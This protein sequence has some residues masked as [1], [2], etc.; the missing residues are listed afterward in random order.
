MRGAV[1]EKKGV[2]AIRDDIPMPQI[3]PYDALVKIVSCGFC[4][5]TDMRII[6]AEMSE[7]QGAQPYPL[8]LGHEAAGIIETLG[9]K[10]RHLA[11]GEKHIR[12]NGDGVSQGGKY[13]SM[14][15]QM[16]EYGVLTD[17]QAM[18]EDGLELPDHPFARLKPSRLPD[19]FDLTDA[20]V[21]LPLCECLSAVRNF[22]IDSNT[23]VLIYGAGP[24]GL[25]LMQYMHIVGAKSVVAIDSVPERLQKAVDIANVDEIHNFIT[26]DI[27]AALDGR[28][29]DRV[30][31]AVGLSSVLL[32]GTKRL[33]PFGMLCSLGVL[34]K[35]DSSIDLSYLKNNTRLQMLNFPYREY[36]V[37][38]ENIRY[39]KEGKISP[40][41]YY[42][43]VLPIE[44]INEAIELVRSKEAIKVI[45]TL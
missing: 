12:I 21:L 22:D 7:I 8:V 34:K 35:G 1:V 19:D 9:E 45:M 13:S 10:V 38:D 40:K 30:I 44:K 4:N 17:W 16:A 28:L 2:V 6:D 27:D 26:E 18:A 36:E 42:S 29:F 20:G 14:H 33:R 41:D 37:L 24:M 5:G 39:F 15:G 25:A 23:D 32:E 31:D 3:G 11:V 43:H